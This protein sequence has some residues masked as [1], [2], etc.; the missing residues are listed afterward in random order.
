[1]SQKLLVSV[2][3]CRL[4]VVRNHNRGSCPSTN[5]TSHVVEH[6]EV[7]IEPD[8]LTMMPTVT[9]NSQREYYSPCRKVKDIRAVELDD[10]ELCLG[11]WRGPTI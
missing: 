7:D 9:S 10:A 6:L 3:G 8:L 2:G 4:V 1:M 11:I 5:D